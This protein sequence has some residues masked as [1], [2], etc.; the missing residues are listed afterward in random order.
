M[1]EAVKEMLS[2]LQKTPSSMCLPKNNE[3]AHNQRAMHLC[4]RVCR[5]FRSWQHLLHYK[6]L[7]F[8]FISWFVQLI[9]KSFKQM[10][11]FGLFYTVDFCVQNLITLLLKALQSVFLPPFLSELK[12]FLQMV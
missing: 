11:Y 4:V 6:K 5:F 1:H 9:L 3:S 8:F 10:K 12:C 7:G 2:A